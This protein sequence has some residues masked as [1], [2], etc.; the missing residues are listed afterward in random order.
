MIPD[1]LKSHP[2]IAAVLAQV[3]DAIE[4]AG[5]A[6]GEKTVVVEAS[7]ILDVCRVLRAQGFNRLSSV[8]AVD[9]HPTEPRFEVVYHLQAL[10]V[11]DR[12]P[13]VDRLRIK[14][15][16]HGEE[17]EIDSATA[18]WRGAEW[19]E[20][21][22]FDLFG[23]VFRNHPNLTRIMMPADWQGHPLRK[24][25]PVHGHKYDYATES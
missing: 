12:S 14:A 22:V 20:R 6:L 2:A 4:E 19:Y 21:E 3:P 8:T 10:P 17:A 15:R 13:Q 16:L 25:F 18:V 24:D 11:S 7:R 23:I 9:W 1:E 5:I